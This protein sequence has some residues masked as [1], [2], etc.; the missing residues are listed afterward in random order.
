[1]MLP[2]SAVRRGAEPLRV[3]IMPQH[4]QQVAAPEVEPVR[5]AVC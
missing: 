1:M 2:I 3:V 4:Y 5:V